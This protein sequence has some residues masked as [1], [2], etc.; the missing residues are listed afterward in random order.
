MAEYIDREY[1]CKNVCRCAG[2]SKGCSKDK[3]SLWRAN[4]SDVV[5]AKHGR[6]I[7]KGAWHI[8]CSEC[9][10]ILAHIDEAKN[11]CPYCGA[12]MDAKENDNE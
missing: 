8:E 5:E 1:Y 10:Y 2:F 11:Y 9:N 3:C 4:T 7:H 12:K 6:W